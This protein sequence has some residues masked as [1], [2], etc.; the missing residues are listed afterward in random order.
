MTAA[1]L[2]ALQYATAVTHQKLVTALVAAGK[3]NWQ[4]FGGGDG[5]G[6]AV[7]G[8]GGAVSV[9]PSITHSCAQSRI[10]VLACSLT[11]SLT[12]TTTRTHT[13]PLTRTRP[14]AC[15]ERSHIIASL[16]GCINSRTLSH[17]CFTRSHALTQTQTQPRPRTP[18]SSH[19]SRGAPTS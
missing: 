10:H 16:E 12:H 19:L 15:I 5:A 9:A 8:G 17:I 1:Q 4:A 2:A 3:Y 18:T 13:N 7:P 14:L 6:A 11:Y